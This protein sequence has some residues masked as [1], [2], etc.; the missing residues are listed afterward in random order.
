MVWVVEVV[1]VG[2]LCF[3]YLNKQCT[4]TFSSSVLRCERKKNK[5]T[6]F[7]FVIGELVLSIHVADPIA[8]VIGLAAALVLR[9]GTCTFV[10]T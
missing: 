8:N 5:E 2:I 6:G 9:F 4:Y 10:Q 3:L 7:W 1:V